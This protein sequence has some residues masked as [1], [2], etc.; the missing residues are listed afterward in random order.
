[1]IDTQTIIGGRNGRDDAVVTDIRQHPAAHL[2]DPSGLAPV[3]ASTIPEFIDHVLGYFVEVP[4]A[5]RVQ[6]LK[7]LLPVAALVAGALV[8]VIGPLIGTGF[9]GLTILIGLTAFRPHYSGYI[10]IAVAPAIVGFG[11]G[12][13]IP[14]LR[15]N[16]ALLFLLWVVLGARWLLYSRRVSVRLNRMDLVV[17]GLILTGL[18]VPLLVQFA[19]LRPVSADDI[20]YAFVLVRLGLLYGIIRYTIRTPGEVR[21]AIGLSLTVASGLGV[22]GLMDSLNLFDTAE[23][24]NPYFPNAGP[25]TDDGRGAA[26]I[27]NPI[28]FGVY[29]GMNAGLAVAM[30]LG[31]ERPRSLLAIAAICCA[32]GVF[33]SGQIGPSL[34][35]IVGLAALALLTRSVRQMVLWSLPIILVGSIVIAP[36]A[37]ERLAGFEGPPITGAQRQDIANIE[38][39]EESRALFDA[40]PGSSWDVR[41]YNLRTF[42]LPEFDD[43]LNLWLGVSPQARVTSPNEGEDF[44]WI[45]SGHLWL[46]WSGGVPLFIMFFLFVGVGL[47]TCRTVMRR[48]PGPVGICGAAAFASLIILSVATTFDPHLTLR[49]TSDILF[50]LLGLVMVGFNP[51]RIRPVRPQKPVPTLAYTT[52][53][54]NVLRAPTSVNGDRLLPSGLNGGEAEIYVVSGAAGLQRFTDSDSPIMIGRGRDC[55]VRIPD[56]FVSR[57]HLVLAWD[58]E[59]WLVSDHSKH[60]TFNRAGDRLDGSVTL[61]DYLDLVVG[62]KKGKQVEVGLVYGPSIE[63]EDE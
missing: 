25:L 20:F 33:G 13:I 18:V 60:G 4:S 21:T 41:L 51:D 52:P 7:Y 40:N 29:C 23:R 42:F 36:L 22:L 37:Q 56:D 5:R 55:Q 58:G 53:D 1:M 27:G 62:G 46:L 2:R 59:A 57:V 43:D 44:I 39:Q 9:I 31:R 30:L 50:P 63:G 47:V 24:L 16:E 8:A 48:T 49:G 35:F 12:Q 19:R 34:S 6:M 15:P 54:R 38:G 61:A 14:L 32:V 10:M 11:R 45:E 17:I 3:P 28:G 26:T